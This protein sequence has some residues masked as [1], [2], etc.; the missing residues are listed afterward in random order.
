MHGQTANEKQEGGKKDRSGLESVGAT[1]G[2]GRAYEKIAPNQK[3]L[4]KD[5]AAV[6]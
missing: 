1:G 2:R 5:E 4:E 3:G 6:G